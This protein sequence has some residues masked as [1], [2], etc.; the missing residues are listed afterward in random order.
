MSKPLVHIGMPK[1]AS[2]WLQIHLFN[3]AHGYEVVLD[4]WQCNTAFVSDRSFCWQPPSIPIQRNQNLVPVITSEA[5]AGS[6]MSG[7]SNAETMLFRLR[8][9]IPEAKILIMI[10]E[11]ASMIRSMYQLLVNWGYP[12]PIESL[13]ENNL[14]GYVP[15][16]SLDFLKYDKMIESYQNSFGAENVL[17]LPFEYFL[18]E[19]TA[20][21]QK[22]G[23]FCSIDQSQ[24]T[25]SATSS[26]KENT[27]RTLLNLELKRLFNR[28]FAKT[29]F[30]VNGLYHTREISSDAVFNLSTPKWLSNYMEARFRLAVS[31]EISGYYSESNNRTQ[32]LTALDLEK[33]GFD[34]KTRSGF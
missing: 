10:R 6:P 21:I 12:Y 24:F 20:F 28:F 3:A 32:C 8:A 13:L 23:G 18:H 19:P 26:T 17:V 29:Q 9:T 16:F 11:Q 31:K 25:A 22:I 2:K 33:Y 15:H 34:M 7:G 30:N 27:S 1:C 4:P 5:L 14:E